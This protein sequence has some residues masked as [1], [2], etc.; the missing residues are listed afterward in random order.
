MALL[1]LADLYEAVKKA[2][3]AISVYEPMPANSPMQRNA[4]IQRALGLDSLDRTDEAKATLTK[5]IA[6]DPSDREAITAL[7][8]ILRGRK[9]FAECADVYS[10]AI[11]TISKPERA[12][13]GALLLPRHLLRALQAVAEKPK[14]T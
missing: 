12:K 2:D 13:L 5:L 9:E 10:K 1:S 14:P 7:G 4:Q 6:A 3:L 11:D 8:N